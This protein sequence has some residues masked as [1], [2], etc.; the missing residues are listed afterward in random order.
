VNISLVDDSGF[1]L[2]ECMVAVGIAMTL[3]AVALVGFAQTHCPLT[4]AQDTLTQAITE[5]RALASTNAGTSNGALLVIT[6][7]PS[8]TQLQILRGRPITGY[9][10][11]SVVSGLPPVQV[12]ALLTLGDSGLNSGTIAFA[13]SGHV[14]LIDSTVTPGAAP[15]AVAPGC[16]STT[17]SLNIRVAVHA[18]TGINGI[19]CMNGLANAKSS[20]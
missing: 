19:N 15:I 6:A 2:L 5:A 1:S 9:N 4:T 17:A 10:T 18:S 3:S 12:N 8:G 14:D 16:G 11:P 13:P 7:N 20:G